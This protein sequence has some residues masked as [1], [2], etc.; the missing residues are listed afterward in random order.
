LIAR[1]N[2]TIGTEDSG[3]VWIVPKPKT[4]TGK[5]RDGRRK[6]QARHIFTTMKLAYSPEEFQELCFVFGIDYDSILGE[7][8]PLKI[9]AFVTHYYRRNQLD[10]LTNF[11]QGDRPEWK[12][13]PE[14][15][16]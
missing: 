1:L 16:E 8:M 11:L 15:K 6:E 4:E 12:W 13:R 3:G 9:M 2:N 14:V 10:V 5:L 7:T